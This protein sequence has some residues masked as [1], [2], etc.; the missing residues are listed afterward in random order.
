MVVVDTFLYRVS[1]V[2]TPDVIS[3]KPCIRGTIIPVS[4]ILK[5]Y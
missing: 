2:T 1:I 3:D 5:A 4:L